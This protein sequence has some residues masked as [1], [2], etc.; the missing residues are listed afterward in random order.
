MASCSARNKIQIP[1]H[2]IWLLSTPWFSYFIISHLTFFLPA[3]LKCL[4]SQ[5]CHTLFPCS[6][7]IHVF[8]QC[9][10]FF[11][12]LTSALQMWLTDVFSSI[13]TLRHYSTNINYAFHF[14]ELLKALVLQ[15]GNRKILVS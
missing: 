7:K 9:R 2:C 14:L 15:W 10:F 8:C 12:H 11:P 3:F 13:V 5:L 1:Q 4:V 6:Q